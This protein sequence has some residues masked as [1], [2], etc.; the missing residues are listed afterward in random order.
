MIVWEF[1]CESRS[2]PGFNTKKE[3]IQSDGLFFLAWRFALSCLSM[4]LP[5]WHYRRDKP[6]SRHGFAYT[7]SM[8][9]SDNGRR[10]ASE[11]LSPWLGSV[12]VGQ[13]TKLLLQVAFFIICSWDNVTYLNGVVSFCSCKTDRYYFPV[14]NKN[15]RTGNAPS[16]ASAYTPSREISVFAWAKRA[17][18][19][20]P[21]GG[22]W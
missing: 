21:Q 2:L 11:G 14:N 22:G 9:I 17:R 19:G 13:S 8:E 4:W 3:P 7:P 5:M 16:I 10:Q 20:Q 18:R 15:A 6:G 12:K 1:P